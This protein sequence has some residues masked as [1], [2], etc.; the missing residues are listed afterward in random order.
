VQIEHQTGNWKYQS[1]LIGTIILYLG[2][3]IG[4]MCAVVGIGDW[5]SPHVEKYHI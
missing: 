3:E 4:E 1:E 2:C 5:R